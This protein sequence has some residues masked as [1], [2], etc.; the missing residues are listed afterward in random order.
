MG[1][2]QYTLSYLRRQPD[3]TSLQGLVGNSKSFVIRS[4]A[5][6]SAIDGIKRH[7]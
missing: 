7:N 2:F 4:R 3:S 5:I 6:V 1:I